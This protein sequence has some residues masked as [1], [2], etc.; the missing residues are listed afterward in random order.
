M[1]KAIKFSADW[2]GPCKVY[3]RAWDKIKVELDG[4]V[5]FVECNVDT[6]TTGLAAEHKVR[7]IPFTVITHDDGEVHKLNGVVK[8]EELKELLIK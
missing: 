4:K 5:E 7:S 6:D 8:Y 3:K 1:V 2:C